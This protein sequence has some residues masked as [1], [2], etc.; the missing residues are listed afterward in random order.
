MNL[1]QTNYTVSESLSGNGNGPG[2]AFCLLASG[3]LVSP[4][5]FHFTVTG[6]TATSKLCT[7]ALPY[8]NMMFDYNNGSTEYYFKFSKNFNTQEKWLCIYNGHCIFYMFKR[9]I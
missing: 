8:N 6:G 4:V 1:E 5:D 7:S 3:D 9:C 2:F